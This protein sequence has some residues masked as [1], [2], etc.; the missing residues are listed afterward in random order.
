MSKPVHITV[1]PTGVTPAGVGRRWLLGALAGVAGLAGLGLAWQR[2]KP[3]GSKPASDE[4]G[5]W[6]LDFK[7][8]QG[9]VL[10]MSSLRGKPLIINFWATWCAPCI[11][12]LPLLNAFYRQNATN[13]WQVLGLAVDQTEPVKRFLAQTPVSF[14]VAMA[15][16]AG[17]E[18]SRELGNASGG[19]PFTVVLGA[20]GQLA[21]RKIGRLGPDDLRLWA[22]IK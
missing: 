11:E 8:P 19:L 15:G 7:T 12:E 5:L 6:R 18:L 2:N 22:R 4:L 14:A 16:L 17:I 9:A 13:G 21:H 20:D 3:T 10:S 1:E